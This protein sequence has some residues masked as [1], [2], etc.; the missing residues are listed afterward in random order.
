MNH[1]MQYH[2]LFHLLQNKIIFIT[3]SKLYG[4]TSQFRQYLLEGY[5]LL[6]SSASLLLYSTSIILDILTSPLSYKR[7]FCNFFFF[8]TYTHTHTKNCF[9]LKFRKASL[10]C[11]LI[12][13][14]NK[15]F[16]TKK[17]GIKLKAT[18]A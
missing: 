1:A 2:C 9:K 15:V 8:N 6:T 16:E 17:L 11:D 4:S 13:K 14:Q 10:Y 18:F 12:Y 3:S 5:F 7:T